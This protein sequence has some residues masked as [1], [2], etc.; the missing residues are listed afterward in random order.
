MSHPRRGELWWATTGGK[1]RPVLVISADS[2]NRRLT[3]V[4][5]IP[6][7]TKLRGWPD[8]IVL[9]HGL[10]DETAFCCREV[11]PIPIVDLISKA[12]RVPD[13]FLELACSRLAS[14]LGCR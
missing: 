2:M 4:V 5:V 11:G 12:G 9:E 14:V 6:G 10:P 1:Q 13:E 8:E 3:R 7:T